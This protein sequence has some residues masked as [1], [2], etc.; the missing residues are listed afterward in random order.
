MKNEDTSS[1]L[2]VAES[3]LLTES[4]LSSSLGEIKRIL[5]EEGFLT[6]DVLIS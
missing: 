6:V 5:I 4:E 3:S 2:Q 1:V